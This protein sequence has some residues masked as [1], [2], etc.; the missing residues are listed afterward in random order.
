[1][2][3]IYLILLAFPGVLNW[4]HRL[5]LTIREFRTIRN[6]ID[7][8]RNTIDPSI[9]QKEEIKLHDARNY[10]VK[11]TS[12][13]FRKSYQLSVAISKLQGLTNILRVFIL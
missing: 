1:L 8:Q 11:K 3:N 12:S 10:H 2:L 7:I 6:N 13:N 5:W 9:F 4:Q